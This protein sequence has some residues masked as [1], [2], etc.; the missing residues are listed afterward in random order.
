LKFVVRGHHVA[1]DIGEIDQL[2]ALLAPITCP[3]KVILMPEGTD[4]ATL[5]AGSRELV[6][7]CR[8]KGWRLS[9]RFHVDLWGHRRGV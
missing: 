3:E 9:P 4:A 7:I 2:L 8:E 6:N 5:A 1:A